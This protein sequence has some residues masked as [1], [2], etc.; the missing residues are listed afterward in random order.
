VRKANFLFV[1]SAIV[2]ALSPSTK[3]LG[4]DLPSQSR[5]LFLLAEKPGDPDYQIINSRFSVEQSKRTERDLILVGEFGARSKWHRQFNV[6]QKFTAILVGKD[7]G[8]KWRRQGLFTPKELFS[9][10]DQMPMR[11]LEAGK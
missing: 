4:S 10:I 8:E 1:A 5:V 2:G 7:G 3:A 9:V 6:Q 11:R